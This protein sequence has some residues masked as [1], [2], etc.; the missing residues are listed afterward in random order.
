MS[1]MPFDR[2]SLDSDQQRAWRLLLSVNSQLFSALNSQLQS[3]SGMSFQDFDVLVY[4]RESPDHRL[5]MGALSRALGWERSRTSHHVVRM[6]RRGM[7]LRQRV[8][9]DGRGALVVATGEG[10]RQLEQAAPKHLDLV[11]ELLFGGMDPATTVNLADALSVVARN[12]GYVPGPTW[13]HDEPG[14]PGMEENE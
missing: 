6:E 12:L 9:G 10:M 7:V 1:A 3:D 11:K 2:Q 8:P 5:R 13:H 14:E 4:L